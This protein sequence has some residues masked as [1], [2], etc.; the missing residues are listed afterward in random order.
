MN[1]KVILSVLVFFVFLIFAS[2]VYIFSSHKEKH[3][4]PVKTPTAD[5]P[6]LEILSPDV[7]V[8]IHGTVSWINATDK[9][10]LNTGDQVKTDSSGIAQIVYPSGTV[11]RIGNNTQISIEDYSSSPQQVNI[12]IEIGSVWSRITKLLGGE[13]YQTESK[14]LVAAVRGTV[15]EHWVLPDGT[16][17]ISVSHHG[18]HMKCT[19]TKIEE[20]VNEDEETTTNC[21]KNPII[22]KILDSEKQTKWEEL[23]REEDQKIITRFKN[24]VYDESSASPI[25]TSPSLL[26]LKTL[27][28]TYSPTP[29]ATASS[30][31]VPLTVTGVT[32]I[33]GATINTAPYYPC[34]DTHTKIQ[35][36]G[37]GFAQGILVY[38][39]PIQIPGTT[40]ATSSATPIESDYPAD[41]ANNP[42]PLLS[43]STSL[44]AHFSALLRGTFYARIVLDGQ[45]TDIKNA[46][47]TTY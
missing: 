18:V 42:W 26:V 30:S 7:L 19:K 6:T 28:P 15:Y 43:G 5:N 37:T 27:I 25:A 23:N 14:N 11:T 3:Q 46:P 1:K 35:I 47:F 40:V 13:S 45:S 21:S 36:T 4:P 10:E 38:A 33:C 34:G 31:P 24:A 8:E 20:D 41:A 2:L 44:I 17:K 29:V 39:V 9:E 16:N 22:S 12:K 32:L